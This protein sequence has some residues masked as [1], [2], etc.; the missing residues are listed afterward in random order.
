[1]PRIGHNGSVPTVDGTALSDKDVGA[2]QNWFLHFNF[3]YDIL[4]KS[5]GQSKQ[6]A[7]FL[8][9]YGGV[10]F[11]H[12]DARRLLGRLKRLHLLPRLGLGK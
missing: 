2:I 4:V 11:T 3:P 8:T 6:A 9:E 7:K 10:P 5:K 12:G 1:M